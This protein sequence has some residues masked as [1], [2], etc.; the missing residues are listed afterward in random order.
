MID[1][2]R[3]CEKCKG[4]GHTYGDTGSHTFIECSNCDGTGYKSDK[5]VHRIEREK[6]EK[7]KEEHTTMKSKLNR[8]QKILNET[9]LLQFLFLS[10]IIGG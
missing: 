1:F 3:R 8:I 2:K 4:T 7:I 9:W 5:E 6:N 10:Y